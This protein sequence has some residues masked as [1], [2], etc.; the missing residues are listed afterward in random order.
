MSAMLQSYIFYG[1]DSKQYGRGIRE[2]LVFLLEKP[3]R[4]KAD[5]RGQILT[6]RSKLDQTVKFRQ[7]N[8]QRHARQGKVRA[9]DKKRGKAWQTRQDRAMYR[10]EC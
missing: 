4:T 5:K 2:R 9:S 7:G 3:K 1:G 6:I 10:P 8:G